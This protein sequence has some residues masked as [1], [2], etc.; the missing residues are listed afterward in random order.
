MFDIDLMVEVPASWDAQKRL[1]TIRK[2][3]RFEFAKG[4]ICCMQYGGNSNDRINLNEVMTGYGRVV[5]HFKG[6]D[7]RWDVKYMEWIYEGRVESGFNNFKGFGR[8]GY[9]SLEGNLAVGY[10]N[11]NKIL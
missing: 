11:G 4:P 5:K 3:R 8:Y 10:W 1:D 9:N 6:K 7:G 2:M